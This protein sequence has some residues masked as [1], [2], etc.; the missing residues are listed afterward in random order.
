MSIRDK[1]TVRNVNYPPKMN[2]PIK[3][4]TRLFS[5]GTYHVLKLQGKIILPELASEILH[6]FD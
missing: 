4:W 6:F 3:G 1:N 5:V 2:C